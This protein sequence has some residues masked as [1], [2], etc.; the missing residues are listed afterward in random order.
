MQESVLFVLGDLL[1]V[2]LDWKSEDCFVS[3]SGWWHR[4]W[5]WHQGQ[6]KLAERE[7][8][9]GRLVRLEDEQWQYCRFDATFYEKTLRR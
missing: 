9:C 2:F 8:W 6:V 5:K 7:V 4:Q 1:G 3:Q